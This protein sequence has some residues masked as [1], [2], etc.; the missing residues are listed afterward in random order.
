MSFL[1]SR[2][3]PAWRSRAVAVGL[4]W[5]VAA[6]A[7]AD[8]RPAPP[9][10]LSE[11]E[12]L[13]V[14]D[15]PLLRSL[16]ADALAVRESAVAAGQLPDPQLFAAVASLPANGDDAYSLS[17]DAD[18]Q[19]Q[20]GIAQEF[21]RARKRRLREA[22]LQREGE[23]LDAEHHLALRS[24]RRDAAL[25]WIDLWHDEQRLRLTRETLQEA[26]VQLETVE[27]ALRSG[28]ATQAEFLA[29]RQEA[30]RLRD[31]VA[32]LDQSIAGGRHMLSRWIGEAAFRPLGGELPLM[33]L[34]ALP[35]VLERVQHHPHLADAAARIAAAQTQA[36][37]A[38]A[39]YRPDWRME[40]GYGYRPEFAE[41]VTLK[42]GIDLPVF[43]RNRQDREL[44]AALARQHASEASLEDAQRHLMAEARQLYSDGQQL[45]LRLQEYDAVL[46]P[47]SEHR[48]A[49]A[50]AGW[51][52]G[53][54]GLRDVLE[55]RRS[56]LALRIARLALQRDLATRL[57]RLG[58]LGAFDLEADTVEN[59]HE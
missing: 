45:N 11:A 8:D 1:A 12:R 28:A 43:T 49:A 13:A 3:A 20:V 31:E 23:R 16:A 37:L 50:L 32:G 10:S 47:Q 9:L 51:R 21:P 38:Q 25:G 17:R 58:Y 59:G 33:P 22:L 36:Q 29:A 54:D 35:T 52:A 2:R 44:A 6:S 39:G 46:L 41:M 53:R 24:V 55:A 48:I 14:A 19:L 57:V 7:S 34:P 40:I 15:Q 5:A 30:D 4:I 42:V 56:A 18:A 27:I 26:E